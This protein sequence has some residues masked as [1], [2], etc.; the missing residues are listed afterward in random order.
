M[1]EHSAENN[2]DSNGPTHEV[3]VSLDSVVGIAT[4]CGLDDQEVGVQVPV[5][6]RI[7]SSPS[8]SALGSTQPPI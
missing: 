1:A 7:F 6:S 4:G 2:L 8:R 3:V 5:G